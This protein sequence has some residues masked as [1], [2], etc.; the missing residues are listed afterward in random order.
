MKNVYLFED[1][2]CHPS[3]VEPLASFLRRKLDGTAEV[4]AFDLGRPKGQVPLP[5]QLRLNW[6]QGTDCLP[7]LVVD[8]VV[9]TQ[10][11]VPNFR[12]AVQLIES[13]EPAPES[14]RPVAPAASSCD[15]GP[16]GCC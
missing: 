12:D 3:K 2:G 11:W 8:S 10:G 5:L 1:K 15:C 7:A 13:G 9:V 16:G 4:S 6:Q 14:M